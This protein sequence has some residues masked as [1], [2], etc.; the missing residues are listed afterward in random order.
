MFTSSEDY[1]EKKKIRYIRGDFDITSIQK[2]RVN[3]DTMRLGCYWNGFWYWAIHNLILGHHFDARNAFQ[4]HNEA[5]KSLTSSFQRSNEFMSLL[6][7][8]LIL[9]RFL[10]P[11]QYNGLKMDFDTWRDIKIHLD[12]LWYNFNTL[13]YIKIHCDTCRNI[14]DTILEAYQRFR[15]FGH[16][17]KFTSTPLWRYRNFLYKL[18]FLEFHLRTFLIWLFCMCLD[19]LR[20]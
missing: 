7:W 3:L 14:S 12:T 13:W 15:R 2:S 16:L 19:I 9:F 8:I 18:R 11:F 10:S 6:K 1:K 5:S 4:Y 20:L 17:S